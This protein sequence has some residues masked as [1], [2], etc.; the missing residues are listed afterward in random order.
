MFEPPS[1]GSHWRH[2]KRGS[3]YTIE[4]V[5][6]IEATMTTCVIY[7]AH[8]DGTTWVR[9]LAEFMDGRFVEI[10]KTRGADHEQGARLESSRWMAVRLLPQMRV[11]FR[12][13]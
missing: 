13:G 6:V 12:R 9:P 7:R 11:Q 3:T 2:V 8:A 10:D 1:T 5:G 4:G